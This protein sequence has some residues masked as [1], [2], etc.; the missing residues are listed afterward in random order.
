MSHN[1]RGR[2]ASQIFYQTAR[3]GGPTN[4]SG[5]RNVE[6]VEMDMTYYEVEMHHSEESFESLAHM[7]YDLFCKSNRTVRTLLSLAF[8]IAGVLN[9]SSWWGIL[10][11]AY[12]CY[13]TTS[14]YS[15]A[16]HTAHK[17]TA[18]IK[19][20]GMP[21]PASRYVFRDKAMDVIPLPA[22][23]KKDS[24]LAYA[25]IC[26]LGEDM[27]YF[28]LFRDQFGGYMV[29]KAALGEKVPDFRLFLEERS[30]LVFHARSAPIIRVLHR[31]SARKKASQP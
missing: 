1:L 24:S 2:V 27:E 17:L 3:Q 7:Q 12:G 25:D 8:V 6:Q 20:S 5:A 22:G 26:R 4:R 15:S 23:E 13:L 16:N 31:I 14:T 21:F 10:L 19:E 28:Y 11:V 30:G 29:P 18:Q 9:F